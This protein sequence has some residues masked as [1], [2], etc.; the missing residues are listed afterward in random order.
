M[1]DGSTAGA[2]GETAPSAGGD[3]APASGGTPAVSAPADT[4]PT[5]WAEALGEAPAAD[6]ATA[7]PSDL[8]ALVPTPEV[9]IPL[10]SAPEAD[11]SSDA[12]PTAGPIPFDRHKAALDNARTKAIESTVQQVKESYGAGIDFQTRFDADPVGTFAQVFDGLMQH[13]T[14]GPAVLSHAAKALSARRGQAA[15]DQEPQPDLQAADGTLLYSAEQLAKREAWT[16][17]RLQAE[18]ARALTPFQQREQA[19]Q[20]Q[21]A[22]EE[23]K[24]AA[25]QRMGTLYQS[26]AVQPH[27]TANKPAIVARFKALRAEQPHLDLGSALGLAYAEVVQS[28]VLPQQVASQQQQVQ[29]AAVAK[30]TGRSTPPGTTIAQPQGRPRT[31][32]EALAQVG[33]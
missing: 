18:M 27:F 33:L 15:L 16:H 28:Q 4:R 26:F 13:P 9:A 7:A 25:T 22:M 17:R 29:A 11:P 5:S 8:P 3:T 20:Q 24:A 14:F 21:Q 6:P 10:P 32:R 19:L 31:M 12:T 2:G 23:A 30:A 1:L